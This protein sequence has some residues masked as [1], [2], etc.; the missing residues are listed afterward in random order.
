MFWL[1]YKQG[2]VR[3]VFIV[4][5]SFLIMARLKAALVLDGLKWMR[6]RGVE[7]AV[8]NT[9]L[10][11]EDARRLYLRLGFH[12]QPPGLAVLRHDLGR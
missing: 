1:A 5:A 10:E 9:Q 4:R 7:R 6:R 11:N 3:C 12:E 8:V 2:S